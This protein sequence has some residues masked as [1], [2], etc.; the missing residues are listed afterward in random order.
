[1]SSAVSSNTKPL[2]PNE[3]IANEVLNAVLDN[4]TDYMELDLDEW[5][6]QLGINSILGRLNNLA[7][8]FCSEKSR[9]PGSEAQNSKSSW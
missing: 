4:D 2:E 5:K 9:H 1:M 6:E 8:Q 3:V 7:V